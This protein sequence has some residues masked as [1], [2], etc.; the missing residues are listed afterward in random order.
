MIG[1]GEV[2][3]PRY[4]PAGPPEARVAWAAA[5][6]QRLLVVEGS[7]DGRSVK[8]VAGV[9]RVSPQAPRPRDLVGLDRTHERPNGRPVLAPEAWDS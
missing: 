7:A 6:G 8:V 1:A 4:T 3:V 5:R 2:L 9:E